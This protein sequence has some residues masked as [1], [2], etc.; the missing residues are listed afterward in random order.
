ML[1][2]GVSKTNRYC[3]LFQETNED[4]QLVRILLRRVKYLLLRW[5]H[6]RTHALPSNNAK[7]SLK[8]VVVKDIGILSRRRFY[9]LDNLFIND[10]YDGNSTKN[11]FKFHHHRL[12]YIKLMKNGDVLDE[13]FM[14]VTNQQATAPYLDLMKRVGVLNDNEDL[15]FSDNEYI[16]G[17]TLFGFDLTNDHGADQVNFHPKSSGS[18]SLDLRFENA[19]PN[20]LNLLMFAEY[21]NVLEIDVNRQILVDGKAL[22]C[23]IPEQFGGVLSRNQ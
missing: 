6:R 1:E 23:H 19:L 21:D 22:K 11:P 16:I 8:G 5:R 14:D 7:Y 13:Y 3:L 9:V 10:S 12:E 20:P 15:D 2:A 4:Y 17:Y 18:L